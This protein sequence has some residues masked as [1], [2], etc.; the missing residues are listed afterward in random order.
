MVLRKEG[1]DSLLSVYQ[2]WKILKIQI[3][4]CFK[5]NID[6]VFLKNWKISDVTIKNTIF[7]VI[8]FSDIPSKKKVV[9]YFIIFSIKIPVQRA[10]ALGSTAKIDWAV[11]ESV[12]RRVCAAIKT[13][14]ADIFLLLYASKFAK[15]K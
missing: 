5:K 10:Q 6:R 13:W 9:F 4:L 1:S 7:S 8:P 14:Y 12:T 11:I 3:S 15:I 2:D